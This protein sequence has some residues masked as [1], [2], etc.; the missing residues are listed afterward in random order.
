[1]S[2]GAGVDRTPVIRCTGQ[3]CPE[4]GVTSPL[5]FGG[6]SHGSSTSP[7]RAATAWPRSARVTVVA[8]AVATSVLVLMNVTRTHFFGTYVR[9]R[10]GSFV[11]WV[12]VAASFM[13]I[14][15]AVFIARRQNSIAAAQLDLGM[16]QRADELIERAHARAIRISEIQ[17][18]IVLRASVVNLIDRPETAT[19]DE[20]DAIGR[21]RTEMAQ[22]GWS[23]LAP[24]RWTRGP[25]QC[26]TEVLLSEPSPLLTHPWIAVIVVESMSAD[27]VSLR[28]IWVE[29]RGSS[30]RFCI[31]RLRVAPGQTVVERILAHGS[32][33]AFRSAADAAASVAQGGGTVEDPIAT[34][35]LAFSGASIT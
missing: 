24:C 20:E 13:G 27:P 4:R 26:E 8:L 2:I 23:P 32:N 29:L 1:M 7:A 9:E 16:S 6:R 30:Q 12:G 15:V 25:E 21:W 5:V 34:V 18:S 31:D 3:A 28:D 17:R 33:G 10:D 35:S 19:R 22:R 14:P 11:D